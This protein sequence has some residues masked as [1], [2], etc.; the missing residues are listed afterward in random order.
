MNKINVALIT[1]LVLIIIS[2]TTFAGTPSIVSS[3]PAAN[4][5][6]AVNTTVSVTFSEAITTTTVTK[7]SFYILDQEG[8]SVSTNNPVASN[9][10]K[11]FTI[12]PSAN[13]SYCATYTIVVTTA[14][15]SSTNPKTFLPSQ[16]SRSFSTTTNATAPTVT[17]TVPVANATGVVES[18]A[19][20]ATFSMLMDHSTIDAS[21]F[22]LDNGA[23]GNITFS[24]AGNVTTAIYTPTPSLVGSTTY[25]AT[26]SSGAKSACNVALNPTKAWQFTTRDVTAPYVTST[27]PSDGGVKIPVN[28]PITINFSEAMQDPSSTIVVKKGG[29]TVT[30]TATFDTVSKLT[31]TFT[32]NPVLDYN[33][34]Y[35]VTIANAKDLAGNY[36]A[37]NPTTFTFQTVAQEISYYCNIPPFVSNSMTPN[38]LLIMDNSNSMDEDFKG[39]AVGSFSTAS[40]SVAGKKA[41]RDI[42]QKYSDLMRIGLM[43]YKLNS[44]SKQYIS[45]SPYFV[46]YEPKSYCPTPPA[47]CVDYCKTGN[48]SSKSTCRSE[49]QIQNAYFDETYMDEVITARALGDTLRNKYCGLVY[50]KTLK[51]INPTDPTRYVYYK[52]ALPFYN[53]TAPG[54]QFIYATAYNPLNELTATGQYTSFT[55]GIYTGKTSTNDTSANYTG[56]Q[57]NSSFGPTDSD[58]ALGYG[59]FGRRNVSLQIGRTWFA[60]GSPGGGYL[61]IPI[62][63]NDTVNTQKNLLLT[64]LTTYEGD[65]TGYMSCTSTTDP[66]TCSY[67]INSG[68]TPTAGT[69]Q[70]ARDYFTGSN[71]PIQQSCQQNFII[72]V[73]DGLP[74]VNES[75]TTA[76][77]DA[78][79]PAVYTKLDA[80]RSF[81]KNLS[82]TDYSFDAKT[83]VLGLGLTSD[84]MPKLEN[85]A[86]HGGTGQ[87]YYANN[88]SQLNDALDRIFGDILQKV[89]SGTSASIVNNRGESGANLFQAAFYPKRVYS[90]TEL[91]WVG[92]LKNMWYYLDPYMNSSSMREDT[93]NNRYLDLLADFRISVDYDVS[94]KKTVANWYQ[95]TTGKGNFTLL[96]E[97]PV[98]SGT[99]TPGEPDDVQPLWRAGGLLHYRSAASRIIKTTITSGYNSDYLIGAGDGL[100]NFTTTNAASLYSLLNVSD[101]TLGSAMIEYTR[102]IDSGSYRNRT[103]SITYPSTAPAPLNTVIS[104]VWKLGDIVSSTP[105]AQTSKAL[106]SFDSIYG[107]TS[108]RKYYTSPSYSNRNMAYV[109]ANDGMLHAFRIGNVTRTDY[110]SLRPYTVAKIVNSDANL[111]IGD[112]EWAFIPKNALPYLK[113]LSDTAYN[114]IYYVNNT[115]KLLDASINASA[116]SGDCTQATYWKCDKFA[117]SW[118]T[119]L[120][121]GMGLGGASRDFS[122]YCNKTDGSTPANATEEAARLDCV[123]SPVANTGLSSFFALDVTNPHV[124]F[125][126]PSTPATNWKFM[127]EFSDAVLP[128]AD[129]GLGFATSGPALVRVATRYKLNG[130]LKDYNTHRGYPDNN[131]N[132]R[133]F[134]V[135]ATG[136]SGPIDTINHQFK[137]NSDNELKVYVV[138]VHPDMSGGWVKGTN[139]WV[140]PSGIKNAFAGDI[141]NSVVDTEQWN[142]SYNSYY[143]D[144]VVYIGYTRPKTGVV[145]LEWTD[146]GVLRLLTNNS[147]NPADWTLSTLID[148]V[149]PVTSSPAKVQD[150]QNGNLWI[151][152]GTGRYFWKNQSGS[153]D[154]NNLRY[155]VGVKE[156]CY[157]GVSSDYKIVSNAMNTGFASDTTTAIGCTAAA[158][159]ALT[160]SDLQDQSTSIASTIGSKK[161][162]Y[163]QL[164]P[165]GDY[166]MGSDMTTAAYNAERVI[167]DTAVTSSGVVTFYS[168]K[169]TNNVCSYGG[170]T[171]PWLVDYATGGVPPASSLVGKILVQLSGGQLQ[172]ID[173][174][175]ATKAKGDPSQ[176][177]RGDRRARADLA[178]QGFS[179]AKGGNIQTTVPGLKKILHI[180]ER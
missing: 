161:G 70:S 124:D 58:L 140:F 116:I 103:V 119:I 157:V 151:F 3:T 7:S 109:G 125:S 156:S 6:V 120:I 86:I 112:E 42:V 96:T 129:R 69:L 146:G 173:M 26:I 79:M 111:N 177:T 9:S 28:S 55:Y 2:T 84:A 102:G 52:Q 141:S 174:A 81:T 113:Y 1:L 15:K 13:L 131:K 56:F 77:A 145:P 72:Y 64:K 63:S 134:A 32:P 25:T 78:L 144:D 47:E 92:D 19:I 87:A 142:S 171:L 65:E 31:A 27:V 57:F 18:A 85:M 97:Y 50:P 46:S 127:W 41:L 155:L 75:G 104:G 68:L 22:G 33:T 106:S 14:V 150:R 10:N 137:G 62:D 20:Q 48:A 24:T 154:P 118:R 160:L 71:S 5:G 44:S 80:L 100:T 148:G 163:I 152:F 159:A 93:D 66:N 101:A 73:T 136:P 132:G 105:Q 51:I 35:T 49:C 170:A 60:N 135:F 83:Y 165:A 143:T 138:D 61:Q 43:T 147:T 8:N 149:G 108:Y 16:Y 38:V 34:N 67:I 130:L 176:Q 172:V 29:V 82:G 59:N 117:N 139:Y 91:Y 162:W 164:D 89:S 123:K 168:V 94:R 74:S 107:D 153:D 53:S 110:D 167:T 90:G 179:G 126:N 180:M 178:G 121:G 133:R 98:G 76:T 39:A 12:T 17:S 30:G 158:P 99:P 175:S 4:T 88:S 36:L 37:P 21:V 115:V 169:P 45:N 11:T 95:D 23:T 122:G 128:V 166:A 114:H 54:N 40:K